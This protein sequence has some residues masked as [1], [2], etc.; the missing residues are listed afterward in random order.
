MALTKSMIDR[1]THF[2]LLSSSS[3]K[4]LQ[5]PTWDVYKRMSSSFWTVDTIDLETLTESWDLELDHNQ[6]HIFG[7]ALM[8][9]LPRRLG[10][11]PIVDSIYQSL[12]LFEARCAMDVR[13]MNENIY[14]GVISELMSGLITD[15]A[16]MDR[17]SSAIHGSTYYAQMQD[18]VM[19]WAS[20][21]SANA[22]G[23]LV[24]RV[25]ALAVSAGIFNSSAYTILSSSD[26]L[27][28]VPEL[29]HAITMIQ[30]SNHLFLD[31]VCHLF[32]G[33]SKKPCQS[34]VMQIVLRAV[35]IE[36]QM[37]LE[38]FPL[39]II[40]LTDTEMWWYIEFTADCLLCHLGFTPYFEIDNPFLFAPR[41]VGPPE[42]VAGHN[43]E[44]FRFKYIPRMDS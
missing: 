33:F 10:R 37:V 23:S 5:S 20:K 24:D 3:E 31:F 39:D 13:T 8:V 9:L 14:H 19:T 6:R 34:H 35:D 43:Y 44:L 28:E 7:L 26:A 30:S 27:V 16:E 11:S 12:D 36:K 4:V 29:S 22:N 42:R 38:L 41:R 21:T 15:Y 2:T 17:I 40:G 25:L 1:P 18:W 32:S